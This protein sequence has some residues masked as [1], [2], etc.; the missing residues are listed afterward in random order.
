LPLRGKIINVEKARLDRILSNEE[1][2]TIITA[3][4]AGIGRDNFNMEKLRYYKI[5]IMTDADI[6]GAHIRTLILTFFFRHMRELVESGHIYIAN[7]PLYR[8]SH[9]KTEQ[10]VYSDDERDRYLEKIGRDKKIDIQ[11]YKGLGE[12]NPDQLWKTTMDPDTRTLFKVTLEDA[13]AADRIFTIL[14]GDVVGPRKE[15]IQNN[16]Q[17]VRNLDV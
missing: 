15:F 8:I 13:A 4:G 5:I 12:M 14:M 1:I 11:R 6:D 10:Y 16:A 3:L 9:G 17:Y 2:K 7:P